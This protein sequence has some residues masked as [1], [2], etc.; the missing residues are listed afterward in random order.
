[1]E[2]D[3]ILFNH[4]NEALRVSRIHL[5]Q[6]QEKVVIIS[7]DNVKFFVSKFIFN[8]LSCFSSDEADIIFAPMQSKSLSPICQALSFKKICDISTED[9]QLLGIN[10]FP[11]LSK[12]PD[13]ETEELEPTALAISLEDQV[14]DKSNLLYGLF[15][16]DETKSDFEGLVKN[17]NDLREE[18]HDNP[19]TST[20]TNIKVTNIS[21]QPVDG[22]EDGEILVENDSV[23]INQSMVNNEI[24]KKRGGGRP[25]KTSNKNEKYNGDPIL[26]WKTINGREEI[27]SMTCKICGKVFERTNFTQKGHQNLILN[28]W[29]HQRLH[30]KKKKSCGCDITF[31]N[32]RE[33]ENHIRNVHKSYLKCPKCNSFLSNTD[34]LKKH[35]KNKHVEIQCE[36][37]DY[38]TEDRAYFK[39][40][41][42]KV[43]AVELQCESCDFVTEDKGVFKIHQKKVHTVKPYVCP[44]YGCEKT[45]KSLE[46]KQ[47]H[48]T[49]AHFQKECPECHKMMSWGYLKRHLANAH[50]KLSKDFS[51]YKCGK[52]FYEK[53]M[54]EQHEEV[55]H[56]GQRFR[57]RYPECKN[58]Q[59]YRDASNRTAHERSKHGTT[60]IKFLAKN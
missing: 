12:S 4:C 40:H 23:K 55:E 7:E 25:R 27:K 39:I 3:M 38:V 13:K 33:K 28:H 1:M 42:K 15:S 2:Y 5:Y 50:N 46:Y 24:K 34:S 16:E 29:K 35:L 37:C 53:F 56:K 30:Q 51:C 54:L 44:Y 47:I 58:D 57:C 45:F 8:F 9:L 49:R 48:F 19:A 60:Y 21:P 26:E 41:Q 31:N 10:Y 36:S 17:G 22:K 32:M 20:K 14:P 18:D 43:H 6:N 52:G 59:E 11:K